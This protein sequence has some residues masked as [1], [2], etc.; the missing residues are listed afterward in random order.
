[1]ALGTNVTATRLTTGGLYIYVINS[2]TDDSY[3]HYKLT[4]EAITSDEPISIASDYVF[5]GKD[6]LFKVSNFSRLV[7]DFFKIT[8]R[9]T[10]NND[11]GGQVTQVT[12]EIGTLADLG[13]RASEAAVLYPNLWYNV[14]FKI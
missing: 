5:S 6:T 1:M 11:E 13:N 7:D 12:K 2:T 10:V 3:S 14:T 4:L 8:L 9:L